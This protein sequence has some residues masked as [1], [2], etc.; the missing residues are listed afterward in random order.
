M[1]KL[2]MGILGCSEQYGLRVATALKSSLLIEPYGVASRD[3]EKAKRYAK[4]WGIAKP[5]GSY[6]ELLADPKVDFIYCPLPNHLHY[7]YIKKSADA[8]KPILCEKPICMNAKEAADAAEYCE[9]KG[10]LLMEAFMY[11]FHPQWTRAVEIVR[12]GELGSIM[13]TSGILCFNLQDAKN[14]RNIPEAGGGSIYDVGCYSASAAR[15]LMGAE[16]KRVVCTLKRD[17]VFKTDIYASALLDFGDGRVSSFTISTQLFPWQQVRVLGTGGTLSFEIPFTTFGDTPKRLYVTNETGLRI[18]ETEAVSHYLLE[19]D[20]FAQAVAEKRTVAP[21]PVSDA[22]ANM[23]VL[24]ALFA[25]AASGK[26]EPV[27]RY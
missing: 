19:Y 15:L 22:V 1:E 5:F 8:G 27:E 20:A 12:C 26:W 3:L 4:Q 21:T 2:R 23:A 18:V 24:D 13:S 9:K 11:R 6:E 14:I 25:S 17:P 7:A 16:P 10:V